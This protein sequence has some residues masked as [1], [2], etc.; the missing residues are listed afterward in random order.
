M[1]YN[2]TYP[3]A[4]YPDW[5][6]PWGIRFLTAIVLYYTFLWLKF[7]PLLNTYKELCINV[8]FVHE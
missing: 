1:Q 3:D 4:G 2:S 7:F 6:G 8:L 5:R